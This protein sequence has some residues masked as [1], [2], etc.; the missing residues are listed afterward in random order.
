MIGVSAPPIPCNHGRGCAC[1]AHNS[2]LS[3]GAIAGHVARDVRAVRTSRAA[4]RAQ[5]AMRFLWTTPLRQLALFRCNIPESMAQMAAAVTKTSLLASTL[6]QIDRLRSTEVLRPFSLHR[7]GSSPPSNFDAWQETYGR[8]LDRGR[9]RV[10][11]I[12]STCIENHRCRRVPI[13]AHIGV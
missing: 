2:C 9:F 4:S 11:R 12:G 8:W 1:L 3:I 6:P 10:G 5:A 13:S 7:F